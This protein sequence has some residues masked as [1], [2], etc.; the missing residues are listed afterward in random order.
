MG[1][2][3]VSPSPRKGAAGFTLIELMI[4][5]AIVAILAAVALPAYFD[6]VRKSRRSDAVSAL[7]ALQQAQERFRSSHSSYGNLNSPADSDTL[8]NISTTSANGHYVLSVSDITS[9]S[10]VATATA[11]GRQASDTNCKLMGV[12]LSGGSVGYGS[13]ASALDWS[14]PGRCWAK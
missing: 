9:A 3:F 2:C 14:D 4:A 10:Y 11:Q 12:R 6:S 7:S 8:P 5:V 13:G 1:H